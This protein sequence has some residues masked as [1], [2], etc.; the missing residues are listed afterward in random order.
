M[1]AEHIKAKFHLAQCA[2]VLIGPE[3]M[4]TEGRHLIKD[5]TQVLFDF[6]TYV[7]LLLK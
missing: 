6:V 4:W 1:R 5:M 2:Y 3:I 7:Y